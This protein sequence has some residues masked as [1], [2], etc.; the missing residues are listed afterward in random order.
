MSLGAVAF[1]ATEGVIEGGLCPHKW[2]PGSAVAHLPLIPTPRLTFASS[3]LCSCFPHLSF[4]FVSLFES[5]FLSPFSPPPPFAASSS[6]TILSP[7]GPGSTLSSTP[8]HVCTTGY[9]G[10]RARLFI[11]RYFR[12]EIRTLKSN[13]EAP[14][15]WRTLGRWTLFSFEIIH[16]VAY[17]VIVCRELNYRIV[18]LFVVRRDVLGVSSWFAVRGLINALRI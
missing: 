5:S 1:R 6:A 9:E 17:T 12:T 16:R 18:A 2:L 14:L 8:A 13:H 11:F 10:E 3:F 7:S 4:P 15:K